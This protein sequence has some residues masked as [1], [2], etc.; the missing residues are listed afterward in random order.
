[1]LTNNLP[2]FLKMLLIAAV[3]EKRQVPVSV[4]LPTVG[5]GGLIYACQFPQNFI[6]ENPAPPRDAPRA[7]WRDY[8]YL[9]AANV[10]YQL[11]DVRSPGLQS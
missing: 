2:A 5:G 1:M 8:A 9:L 7:K 10:E 11:E 4:K 6:T 3:M